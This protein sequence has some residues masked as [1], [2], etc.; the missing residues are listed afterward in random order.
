MIDI[1]E[2]AM[3]ERLRAGLGP[4]IAVESYQGELE[5][6]SKVIATVPACW[7]TYGGC[8]GIAS[9]STSRAK[10]NVP[11]TYAVMVAVQNLASE[12]A[13]RLGANGEVGTYQLLMA[14]LKLLT[15][16]R[17]GLKIDPLDPKK[18]QVIINGHFEA[19]GL[20]VYGLEFETKW[21]F[22]CL[23]DGKYPLP[24]DPDFTPFPDGTRD[25]DDPDLLRIGLHHSLQPDDG[26][27]DAVDVVE[28]P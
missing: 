11:G 2:L 25:N 3:I 28:R 27:A 17:L 26:T 8:K 1:I 18:V 10:R 4:S 23:P 6:I 19:A 24:D 16:Q 12:S 15:N 14:V 13:G 9:P 7:V 21:Q 22:E 20:K 5:D